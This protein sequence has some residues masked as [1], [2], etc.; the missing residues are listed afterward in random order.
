MASKPCRD[1]GEP[2]PVDA[3]GCNTCG[4]NLVAE[5]FINRVL[6]SAIPALVLLAAGVAWY[7]R[8]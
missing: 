7:L 2:L 5:R 6:W 8:D 1:C 4:R 3:R